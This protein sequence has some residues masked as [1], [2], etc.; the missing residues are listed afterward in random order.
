MGREL[1]AKDFR[2]FA[3]TLLAATYLAGREPPRSKT[4]AHKA[5]TEAVR[6]TAE[7]LRHRPATCRK[8]YIHPAVFEAYEA[9][10]LAPLFAEH[11][12]EEEAL[13]ALLEGE[14]RAGAGA[15]RRRRAA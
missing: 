3:G 2:T 5:M 1:S 6:H 8:F 12:D 7:R 15:P 10:A 13:L 4:R 11:D 9:G 14:A